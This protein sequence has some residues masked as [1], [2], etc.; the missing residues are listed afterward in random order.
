MQRAQVECKR[1]LY[2]EEII[3][4]KKVGYDYFENVDRN[5]SFFLAFLKVEG[6]NY[7]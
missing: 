3:L 2:F 1:Y 6:R 5:I 7:N 4:Q